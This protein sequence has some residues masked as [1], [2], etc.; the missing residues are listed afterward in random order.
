MG[1]FSP[2][3]GLPRPPSRLL[4]KVLYGVG[5]IAYGV[6][7]N[8]FQVLL[9]LF[10]NQA[11]G[12]NA[13]LAGLAIMIALSI[14][15]MID[16]LI[17]YLSDR[18]RSPL[19]RRHPFMYA[20]AVPV[21]VSYLFLFS[22]PHGLSQIQLF[23]YL[24]VVAVLVR[25]FIAVY[26]IPSAALVA[27]LT[28]SYDERTAFISYRYFFGW[29]G[30]LTMAILAFSVFLHTDA[31]HVA[32]Q[33]NVGGYARY[34]IAASILMFVA[35]LL[36][37]AG[38]QSA[39]LPIEAEVAGKPPPRNLWVELCASL[40]TR[41]AVTVVFA[42]LF[43]LLATGLSW[44]LGTFFNIY[45]FGLSPNQISLVTASSFIS[46]AISLVT[47]P[48]LSRRFDKRGVAMVVS[49]LLVLLLPLPLILSLLGLLPT[50]ASGGLVPFLFLLNTVA[51]TFLI[52]VPTLVASMAADV[53]EEIEVK[54]GHRFEGM[55]FSLNVFA[56]KFASGLAV[57]GAT[58]ILG[59]AHFPKHAVAGAVPAAVITSLSRIYIVT[60]A[61]LYIGSLLCI[62][63]YVITRGKHMEHLRILAERRTS[64]PN[65]RQA[66]PTAVATEPVPLAT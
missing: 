26:E 33:L 16:P 19:G 3:S 10:Y 23:G 29:V 46:A 13:G 9:L 15:A 61:C 55:I 54:T 27:E 47:T 48:W 51:T 44:G 42:T 7:D 53:V 25:I 41:S 49:V 38:T 39:V 66:G 37:A 58:L 20:A 50:L 43:M 52:A 24:L 14:D 5:S 18:L 11:L 6:K 36:S 45:A 2:Q 21:A 40:G 64:T 8:G 30:G 31:A 34:G 57:L 4:L 17:G 12:L 56:Q 63:F 62:F 35:I 60:V 1:F 32:A 65:A 28:Y 59:L 22:P